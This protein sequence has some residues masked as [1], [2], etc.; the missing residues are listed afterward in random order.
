MQDI[1]DI[2]PLMNVGFPWISLI[3]ALALILGL[4][5]LTAWL[6]RKARNRQKPA[7]AAKPEPPIKPIN[8]REQALKALKALKAD[9]R[10]ASQFYFQLEAILKEFLERF[11]Q[12]PIKSFT[13]SQLAQF[14]HQ[15]SHRQAE[16]IDQLLLHGQQAKFA[17]QSVQASQMKQDL[18]QVIS[19]VNQYTL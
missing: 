1:H 16:N 3:V 19:F 2:K 18:E 6:L 12:Q 8:A 11:H 17:A 4:V 5:L 13:A 7:A 15:R 10:H 9:E 14:M